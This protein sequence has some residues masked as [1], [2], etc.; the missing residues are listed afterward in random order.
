MNKKQG[1]AYHSQARSAH[2]FASLVP[3]VY[4]SLCHKYTM[5]DLKWPRND[6]PADAC[7]TCK[8][9]LKG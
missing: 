7:K 5:L 4:Q 8:R 6:A 1:W 9:R 3:G 2:Y